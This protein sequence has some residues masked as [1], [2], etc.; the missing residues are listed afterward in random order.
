MALGLGAVMVPINRWPHDVD[1]SSGVLFIIGSALI[2]AGAL[3]LATRPWT[4]TFIGASIGLTV[5]AVV[6]IRAL[7]I[8]MWM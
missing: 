4:G 8:L 1:W 2:G 3:G 7:N 5:V 6:A